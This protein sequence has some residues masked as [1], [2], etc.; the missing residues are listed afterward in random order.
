MATITEDRADKPR[1]DQHDNPHHAHRWL[2][3]GIIA[4]AQLIVVLD[5]TIVN[6]ALPTAQESLGFSN[7]N[8]QWIVTGYAL[9]FGSLLLVGGRL[10]DLIGR[11][12]M[13]ITGLVGFAAASAVGGAAQNFEMLVSARAAQGVFGALL[14]PAALSLLTVTFTDAS[15]RAKAFAIFGAIAGGGGAIGL[16]LGGVLTEYLSW[17]WCLYVNV[18]LAALAVVGGAILLKKQ[19]RDEDVAGI[20]IPGSVL[21]VAGLVS[22]VYGL[23]SAESEGWSSPTTLICIIAGLA[24]LGLF[25]VVESRVSD[26]LLPLHIVW[27]RT[28]GGAFLTVA[29]VGIGLFAVFLFLTYY[30][31]LTLGYSPVKTGFAFVPLILALIV[32]ASGFAG[33]VARIGPRIPV[34]AG[35]LLA[36]AG[37][38]LFAQLDLNSTYAA[39]ILPGLLVTGLGVGLSVAPAFNASTSG[40]DPE[41]AGVASASVNTFQ[42]IGGSIGTAVLS[43]FAATAATSY[44]DGRAPTAANQA[45]ATMHSYTTVFWWGAGIFAVGALVCGGLLRSGPITVDP[46]AAPVVGH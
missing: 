40:V 4:L 30:V 2:I 37:L 28:R 41:H 16:I 45:L 11:R 27:D 20:D 39:N 12:P 21:S 32:A 46:D 24:L 8:R 3:L 35:L 19:A 1:L 14:A 38:A 22:L 43:A 25:A 15:E 13:F 18:P 6:I 36:A 31:S 7:D 44:L 17:R 26:P 10:S 23:A 5:A 33:V 9:A 29:V 42:Q 34:F